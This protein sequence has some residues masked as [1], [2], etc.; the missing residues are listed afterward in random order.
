MERGRLRAGR[1]VDP[2][3][4]ITS[5]KTHAYFLRM[6]HSATAF[7][8]D[9]DLT[10]VDSAEAIRFCAQSAIADMNLAVPCATKVRESIGLTLH[11]T[12]RFLTGIEDA[13]LAETYAA[14]YVSHADRVM[15]SMTNVYPSAD[16]LLREL[17][18]RN[19]PVGI[20]STKFRRRIE[21]TLSK[22]SLR[23]CVTT[24]IGGEDVLRHKPDPEGILK[25]LAAMNVAADK[26]LYVGDHL[27]DAQA[28][29]AAG[30]KFV[31]VVTGQLT[32]EAWARIG[33]KSVEH[34]IAELVAFVL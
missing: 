16:R 28:A 14:Y 20:V 15:V 1:P 33:C 26:A 24:I 6:T 22:V 5:S 7:L 23:H 18:K 8:F 31:G 3:P 10:L 2:R 13:T 34:S 17:H 4:S 32:S 21:A 30:T 9:F 27:I 12:F 11:D 29:H 19:V 25:A